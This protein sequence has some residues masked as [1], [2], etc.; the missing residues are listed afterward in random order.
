[1]SG[2]EARAGGASAPSWVLAAVIAA[3]CGGSDD[4]RTLI[5]VRVELAHRPA[6][7]SV[8]LLKTTVRDATHTATRDFARPDR[9]PLTF[10]TTFG[11]ELGADIMGP[12]SIEVDGVDMTGVVVVR[13]MIASQAVMA[14]MT[15]TTQ[16]WLECAARCNLDGGGDRAGPRDGG[17]DAP[18]DAPAPADGL[19]ACGNGIREPGETCDTA[20]PRGQ[21][22]ACPLASCDDN[23]PCTMDTRINSACRAECLNIPITGFVNGDKCC[24]ADG[25]HL[26]DSDCS[27][28]C[29]NGR[30]EAGETCDLGIARGSPNACPVA[31]DCI[32]S[33]TCTQ[34]ILFSANTCSARCQHPP[35]TALAAGDRC[36]PAGASHNIDSDCQPV[37]GNGMVEPGESCDTGIAAGKDGECLT[38]TTCRDQNPCTQDTLQG[39]GCQAMCRRPEITEFRGGDGCCPRGGNR[40]LDP[41]CV[42]DCGNGVLEPGES[43]DRGIAVGRPGA[44]PTSCPAGGS[45]CAP[46]TLTGSAADCSARCAPRP[47]TTCAATRDGC[48]PMGCT[49]TTDGD[50]SPT[51]GNGIKEAGE[52]CDTALSEPSPGACVR[53]CDDLNT[54]TDDLLLSSGTCHATCDI[55]PITLFM[56]GDGCCPPG[57]NHNLDGDCGPECGNGVLE[58]PDE[59]C[60]RAIPAGAPGACPTNCPSIDACQRQRLEG[61]P[62]TCSARCAPDP[63]TTCRSGDMCCPAGCNRTSD[64]DCAPI[65]GNGVRE[66]GEECDRGITAGNADACP[67][68]CDDGDACTS[69]SISGRVED[70]NRI[71]SYTRMTACSSGDRCCPAGCTRDTD[72]DCNPVCG[73]M[74]VEAG[75]TCDPAPA[76]PTTCFDDGDN[77]TEERLS[78]TPL[79]CNVACSRVPITACSGAT[80]DGCCPTGCLS[81]PGTT[82]YDTDCVGTTPS[83]RR[84]Q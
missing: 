18:V 80:S 5:N 35:I 38:A 28:S 29:G 47:I 27:A 57:G 67:A 83:P 10:P 68:S 69:D 59:E 31:A 64:A 54:C 37:C 16:L 23:I 58:R 2:A 48:C 36:C 61:A 63:V 55:T 25:T 62:T 7:A 45:A 76:C 17:G 42:A 70:C 30:V 73:N 3:G 1:M 82:R 4:A 65:C 60:D 15:S 74:I 13:G 20:I 21:P 12:I 9:R 53:R 72:A 78:G 51:C 46:A 11:I 8:V 34:D 71:C 43:C 6:E 75:E 66:Q 77:C 22:G 19:S 84:P 56:S 79:M 49:A 52:T 40:T 32:D 44:C 41:D 81:R 39:W 24:P 14:R 26:T 33:D 50:C